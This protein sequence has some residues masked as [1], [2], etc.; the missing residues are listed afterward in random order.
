MNAS[1]FSIGQNILSYHHSLYII[2]VLIARKFQQSAEDADQ[3]A[4]LGPV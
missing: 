2:F 3:N 4:R 1:F